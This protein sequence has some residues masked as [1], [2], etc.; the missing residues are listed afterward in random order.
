MSMK[1]EGMSENTPTPETPLQFNTAEYSGS[2]PAVTICAACKSPLTQSYYTA[3][4]AVLCESCHGQFRAHLA[5]GSPLMRAFAATALGLLAGLAGAAIWYAVRK[6][7][8]YEIGLIAIVVGLMVGVAVR[9]GSKGRGGWFY[10]ALAMTLTYCCIC[11]QYVPDIVEGMVQK[12][13]GNH[14]AAKAAKNAAAADADDQAPAKNSA[15]ER[16]PAAAPPEPGIVGS[17]LRFVLFLV[18]V[19]VLSLALPFL[20]GAQNAIGLLLIGIALYEAWKI[21]KGRTIRIAGPFQLGPAAASGA[22][23]A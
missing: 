15:S 21:N 1:G 8:D 19:F 6:I 9:K 5:A 7:T 16:P 12:S 18:I 10:Q 20:A 13:R 17:T 2:L 3:N 22:P 14:P 11:A 4:K 23:G